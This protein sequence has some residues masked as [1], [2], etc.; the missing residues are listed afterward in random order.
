ML[1]YPIGKKL[2]QVQ[3]C[4][5]RRVLTSIS[6]ERSKFRHEMTGF[7]SLSGCSPRDCGHLP[8]K[9]AVWED[10]VV[11]AWQVGNEF[12]ILALLLYL[13]LSFKLLLLPFN[14][15]L[16][17]PSLID[18]AIHMRSACWRVLPQNY[19]STPYFP[20]L[21]A[22]LSLVQVFCATFSSSTKG[23]R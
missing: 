13:Q 9:S 15:V 20:Q 5:E 1:Q 18:H 3:S 21:V 8:D 23:R 14:P 11:R 19:C 12:D 22:D 7:L 17:S 6:T 4:H 2:V 10:L 16:P